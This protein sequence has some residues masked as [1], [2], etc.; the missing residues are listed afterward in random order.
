MLVAF[1]TELLWLS[2]Q[3]GLGFDEYELKIN[4]DRLHAVLGGGPISSQAKEIKAVTFHKL[5]IRQ[6]GRGKAASIVFDV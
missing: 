5:V 6:T 1:L 2:E 3:E 4:G